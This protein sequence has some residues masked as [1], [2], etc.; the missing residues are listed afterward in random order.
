MKTM[1][2]VL[3]GGKVMKRGRN[4]D[5]FYEIKILTDFKSKRFVYFALRE[6][7]DPEIGIGDVVDIEGYIKSFSY[8]DEE[9]DKFR[10][11]QYFIAQKVEKATLFELL[12]HSYLFLFLSLS[13]PLIH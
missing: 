6:P 9:S 4:E 11:K 5:G 12:P 1:N 3:A 8:K 7:L 10:K 2:K 13:N